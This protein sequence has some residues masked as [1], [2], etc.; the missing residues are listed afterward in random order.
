MGK[1]NFQ[2]PSDPNKLLHAPTEP[3]LL[4]FLN[5]N[6]LSNI[7]EFE[8]VRKILCT[9]SYVF[10]VYILNGSAIPGDE[11]RRNTNSKVLRSNRIVDVGVYSPRK[12]GASAQ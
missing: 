6:L 8:T 7:V 12:G 10:L 1:K 5:T 11:K 4:G 2:D 9:S 3:C